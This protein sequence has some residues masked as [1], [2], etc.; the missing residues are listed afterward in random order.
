[1]L[2]T[3]NNAK[4]YKHTDIDMILK[5]AKTKS[6]LPEWPNSSYET[7]VLICNPAILN[8]ECHINESF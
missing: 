1:M 8:P 4:T 6:E 2:S 3:I 5:Q 7:I